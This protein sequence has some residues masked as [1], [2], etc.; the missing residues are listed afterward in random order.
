MQQCRAKGIFDE[1]KVKGVG[2]W[3]DKDIYLINT[4]DSLYYDNGYHALDSLKGDTIY[5][6]GP[7]LPE[8]SNG[9]CDTNLIL[10]LLNTV[11]WKRMDSA[12]FLAG[13]LVVAPVAG[14]IN[15]RPHLWLTGGA[16]TGKTTIMQSVIKPMLGPMCHY[17]LGNTS[18]AGLRQI[19]RNE[20]KAVICDEFETL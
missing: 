7:K 6:I 14:A 3:K 2:V 12:R 8:L 18:E 10:L 5:E 19:T 4:G 13:Y 1:A 16:G 15:W 11:S 20:S 9:V 17:F